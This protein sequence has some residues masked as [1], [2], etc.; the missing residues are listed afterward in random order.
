[1]RILD[2][3]QMVWIDDAETGFS[4]RNAGRSGRDN[5]RDLAAGCQEFS[6]YGH[7]ANLTVL[8][9]HLYGIVAMLEYILSHRPSEKCP[10]DHK[11]AG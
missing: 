11:E 6:A 7:S 3:V 5:S 2:K 10:S 8:P 4:L 9:P 1:M